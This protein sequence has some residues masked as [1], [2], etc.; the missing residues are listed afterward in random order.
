MV[1][2]SSSGLRIRPANPAGSFTYSSLGSGR[3]QV[4]HPVAPAAA[5]SALHRC[6][7]GPWGEIEYHHIYLEA[8]EQL[9]RHFALPSTQPRWSFPGV[10]VEQLA[11]LFDAA[12]IPAEWSELWLS[13]KH[14]LTQGDVQ[15]VL[16]PVE[17]LE[18]LMP[19]Q[20]AYIY[21]EL[22]K[23]PENEFHRDPVFI[24]SG[25][26]SDFFR[27]TEISLDHVRWFER[28]CYRRGNVL[29]FSDIPA[30]L[31]RASGASEARRLFKLCS[32]TRA[33]ISWS[34]PTTGRR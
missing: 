27:H 17:H 26:V 33:I 10:T 19:E 14:L 22:A 13:P 3:S 32:R 7:P 30:L 8:S 34:C 29:C 2:P 24:T 6:A 12:R 15:H 28:M 11:A 18:A 9:V 16:L 1:I 21:R 25:S 31:R 5:A 4:G 20:R 23:A